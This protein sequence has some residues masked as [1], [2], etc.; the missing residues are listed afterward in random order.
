MAQQDVILTHEGLK[1][2]LVALAVVA[3]QAVQ[4]AL[5][6]LFDVVGHELE[7]AVVL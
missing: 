7:L 3:Q 2:L 5:D 6:L 1:E 4:L